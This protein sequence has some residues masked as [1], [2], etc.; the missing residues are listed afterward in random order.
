VDRIRQRARGRVGGA[1]GNA[2]GD[3]G[4]GGA[5]GEQEQEQEE[6]EEE[7]EQGARA[8]QQEEQTQKVVVRSAA[9]GGSHISFVQ[10]KMSLVPYA[11][12]G[13]AEMALALS[14]V[15]R[16]TAE[17]LEAEQEQRHLEVRRTRGLLLVPLR[18]THAWL[19]PCMRACGHAGVHGRTQAH[20]CMHALT[21]THAR[22]R[23]HAHAHAC[24]NAH[25]PARTFTHAC[26]QRHTHTRA[27]THMP[28]ACTHNHTH[29]RVQ[30]HTRRAYARVQT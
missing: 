1:A 20:A 25:R 15:H 24:K 14:G 23:A 12:A 10:Y 27:H 28:D 6:E 29:A 9:S 5:E 2:A 17:E 21:D 11:A 13:S 3:A 19:R 4:E 30:G 22:A 8:Q 7:Q 16:K 18:C 26:M